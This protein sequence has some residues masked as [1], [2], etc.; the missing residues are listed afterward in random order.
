MK[1]KKI[2]IHSLLM[3]AI[4]ASIMMSHNTFAA[5][6]T[7]TV[8]PPRQRII[9]TPGEEYRGS[10]KVSNPVDAEQDLKYSTS[11]GPFSQKQGNDSKDDYG[12]VDITSES[13]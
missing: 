4:I 2:F 9:L 7:L 6:S 1:I 10:I 8:S 12:S 3:W 5:K 11:I 13:N